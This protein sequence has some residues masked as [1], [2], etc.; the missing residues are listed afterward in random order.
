MYPVIQFCLEERNRSPQ[1]VPRRRVSWPLILRQR[2]FSP[3]YLLSTVR[4]QCLWLDK[5]KIFIDCIESVLSNTGVATCGYLINS[6]QLKLTKIKIHFFSHKSHISNAY[7]HMWLMATILDSKDVGYFHHHRR[8][9]WTM[10]FYIIIVIKGYALWR[11]LM[12]L[13]WRI[14]KYL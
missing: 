6:K 8:L 7:Y 9:C 3:C 5:R 4:D 12:L 1:M 14:C 13:K 10:L 2:L 11:V